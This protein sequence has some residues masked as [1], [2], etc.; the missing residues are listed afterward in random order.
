MKPEAPTREELEGEVAALRARLQ[1]GEEILRAI[2]CGEVD[3]VLVHGLK[4]DQFFTLKG[5]DGPYRVLIEE[6]NQGAVTLSAEGAILYCNR[7][8]ADLLKRPVEGITGLAFAAFVA[9]AEQPAFVALLRAGRAGESAGEITLQASDDSPVPLQLALCRLPADSAAAICLVATDIRESREKGTSLLKMMEDL[10]A[11][12]RVL[13][14][15]N[16]DLERQ[17]AE[18]CRVEEQLREREE[19]FRALVENSPDE[20]SRFDREFRHLYINRRPERF[21][22]K[23]LD[24]SG[25]P[26]ELVA[27]WKAHFQKVF[28]TGRPGVMEYEATAENGTRRFFQSRLVPEFAPGGD[29]DSVLI[30]SRDITARRQAEEAVRHSEEQTRLIV[31]TAYDAFIAI[32]AAGCTTN[33]NTQAEATFGWTREEAIGRRLS[34]TIIPPQYQQAHE[35]GMKHFHGTGHGPVLNKRIEITAMHR[36]GREFPVELTIWP[37]KTGETCTFNAFIRDITE[38]KKAEEAVHKARAEA[39]RANRAKSEFISRMSQELRTPMNAILGFAQLLEMENPAPRQRESIEQILGSGR[40]LFELFD[41]VLDISRIEAGELSISPEP[42]RVSEVLKECVQLIRPLAAQRRVHLE[43]GACGNCTRR[44][45]ADRQRFKQVML[46]LLSNAVKYN[47]ESGRVTVSCEESGVG[48]GPAEQLDGRGLQVRIKIADTGYG[49]A[50]D[51]LPRLFD[52][53]QRVAAEQSSVEGTGLGL[54]LSKRLI[55]VMGGAIGAESTVGKGSVFWVELPMVESPPEGG[56]LAAHS[57]PAAAQRTVLYIEDNLSNLRLIE[58]VLEK[59]MGVKLIA[60]MQGSLGMELAREHSP[61]LILLDLNL[62]DMPGHE[63]LRRL[64]GEAQT[65]NTPV[66]IISADATPRSIERLLAE[67]ACAYLSKPLDVG[68]FLAVIG[69]TLNGIPQS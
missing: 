36:D 14:G 61:E 60:A 62:P 2:R 1:E 48:S 3:A 28:D 7:R 59:L 9:P 42:V 8:F 22:G 55:D 39:E 46:N 31:D 26:A 27:L 10:V 41:E 66:V 53:F 49:I 57:A 44:V 65:R 32:D 67:G 21:M 20:I 17:I 64:Q 4:G 19:A 23:T 38:S 45:M 54:A 69:R 33:W 43:L 58:R 51:D 63:V 35:R 11:T 29:V 56:E 52:A 68:E 40:H 13:A 50:P 34:E 25:F 6:M 18:R 24:E 12:Q 5:A 16:N 30:V 37:I 15:T 47:R